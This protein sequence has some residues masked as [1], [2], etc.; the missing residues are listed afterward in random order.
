MS[1]AKGQEH[2]SQEYAHQEKMPSD[3][4]LLETLLDNIPDTI[5]FKDLKSRFIKVNKAW[6][7][8]V[9][10]SKVEGKTDFDIFTHEHAQQ[11]FEDEMRIIATDQPIVGFEEKETWPDRPDT[12]VSTTKM[13]L[14]DS[15]G[16]VI[17]T[18]GLSRDITEVKKI[19]FS[20][21][22]A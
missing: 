22:K 7:N 8:K 6:Q 10:R 14:R 13:P 4:E 18:F 12:W 20:L 9:N 16:E 3:R 19:G 1:A 17:G 15:S 2:G 21:Q 11:A 5:Y